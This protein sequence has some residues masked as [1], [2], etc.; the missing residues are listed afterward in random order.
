[1]KEG[2]LT[3]IVGSEIL[4]D[5]NDDLVVPYAPTEFKQMSMGDE[6]LDPV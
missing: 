6:P 3:S 2:N 1:M 5:Q 4:T